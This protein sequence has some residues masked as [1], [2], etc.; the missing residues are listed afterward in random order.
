MSPTEIRRCRGL[1]GEG[2][3]GVNLK[4]MRQFYAIFPDFQQL[5][6]QSVANLAWMNIRMIK[7]LEDQSGVIETV[8]FKSSDRL[9]H[10]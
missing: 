9:E 5:A 7:R 1:F 2:V 8:V 10:H 6:T 4:N 3:S